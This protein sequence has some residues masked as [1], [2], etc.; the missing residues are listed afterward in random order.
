MTTTH[1]T[2]Y[3]IK[4]GGNARE[5]VG[6]AVVRHDTLTNGMDP[7]VHIKEPLVISL[8]VEPIDFLAV[9]CVSSNIF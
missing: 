3:V 4:H 5:S 2:F 6:L 8:A 1:H 9:R 7:K